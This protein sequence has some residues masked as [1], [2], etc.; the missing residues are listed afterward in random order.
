M[1]VNMTVSTARLASPTWVLP[2]RNS[3][4]AVRTLS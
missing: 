2:V 4:V 1:S 3:S